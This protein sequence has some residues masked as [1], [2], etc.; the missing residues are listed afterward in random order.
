MKRLITVTDL[1]KSRLKD[2]PKMTLLGQIILTFPP[3]FVTLYKSRLKDTF[4]LFHLQTLYE[5]KTNGKWKVSRLCMKKTSFLIKMRLRVFFSCAPYQLVGMG[6]H[7]KMQCNEIHFSSVKLHFF[8]LIF[9]CCSCYVVGPFTISVHQFAFCFSVL[10]V[11]SEFWYYIEKWWCVIENYWNDTMHI[12]TCSSH[13]S[14]WM[15]ND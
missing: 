2:T 1:Y 7:Y 10:V 14:T 13:V 4:I 11:S 12:L 15:K 8:I 3:T 9:I 5:T 6:L